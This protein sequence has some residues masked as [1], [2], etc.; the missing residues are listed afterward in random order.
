M[1][2]GTKRESGRANVPMMN[3]SISSYSCPLCGGARWAK[4]E[5]N[6]LLL[7]VI[8]D[9]GRGLLIVVANGG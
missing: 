7:E 9:G 2:G 6:G 3:A 4:S 8:Y 5:G 1:S